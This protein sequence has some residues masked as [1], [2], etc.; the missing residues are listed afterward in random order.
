MQQRLV[1]AGCSTGA[2]DNALNK[3]DNLLCVLYFSG[4]GKDWKKALYYNV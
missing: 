1:K 3:S 2:G 4:G